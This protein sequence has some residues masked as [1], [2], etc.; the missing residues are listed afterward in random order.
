MIRREDNIHVRLEKLAS[1]EELVKHA[2]GLKRMYRVATSK[3]LSD[4]AK[5]KMLF[6]KISKE[7]AHK[8]LSK[9][10]QDVQNPVKSIKNI[11]ERQ[12]ALLG[13]IGRGTKH[14]MYR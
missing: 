7:Q 10:P 5:R 4:A 3:R 13:A 2:M 11:K 9:L 6:G 14:P 8:K 1:G 12:A